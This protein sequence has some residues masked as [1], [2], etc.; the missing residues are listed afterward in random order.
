MTS[1]PS[2]QKDE[3]DTYPGLH[4]TV[5]ATP[6]LLFRPLTYDYL[7]GFFAHKADPIINRRWGPHKDIA[8]SEE[9]LE[10]RLRDP[11]C[12]MF[13]VHLRLSN[14]KDED[15]GPHL[16]QPS[17]ADRHAI[18]GLCGFYRVPEISASYHPS[19]WG[20]GIA[21]EALAGLENAYW[22]TFP[23]GHPC[24][25]VHER[26]YLLAKTRKSNDAASASL[27]KYGYELWKEA[28]NTTTINGVVPEL[29]LFWRKWKPGYKVRD[30]SEGETQE[31]IGKKEPGPLVSKL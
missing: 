15:I 8:E 7:P 28:K 9:Y 22:E 2:N 23:N 25:E 20:R 5:F 14:L 27:R 3:T 12:W 4:S 17:E 11:L 6:R 18:I 13:V 30:V 19:C 24:V 31:S 29:M 16:L 10:S 1:V 21:T 26:M